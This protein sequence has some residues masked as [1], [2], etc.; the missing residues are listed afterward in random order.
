MTGSEIKKLRLQ[1][2][3]TQAQFAKELGFARYNW[4]S[5]IENGKA[6]VSKQVVKICEHLQKEFVLRQKVDKSI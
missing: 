2:K 1:L 3:M 5:E 6:P 4:L